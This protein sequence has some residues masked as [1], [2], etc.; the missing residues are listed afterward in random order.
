[1][2]CC[3]LSQA[4][5]ESLESGMKQPIDVTASRGNDSLADADSADNDSMTYLANDL[6]VKCPQPESLHMNA[7]ITFSE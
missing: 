6:P 5:Q 4:E 3:V 2:S 1:M 7:E